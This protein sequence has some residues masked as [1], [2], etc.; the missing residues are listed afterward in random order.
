MHCGCPAKAIPSI[1][2]IANV[3]EE[4]TR[5]NPS[6]SGK[7]HYPRVENPSSGC[8][9]AYM[10]KETCFHTTH[11]CPN[12]GGLIELGVQSFQV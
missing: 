4:N 7:V 10:Y 2:D 8:R 6:K 12:S 11:S 5:T 3:S 1:E 9:F